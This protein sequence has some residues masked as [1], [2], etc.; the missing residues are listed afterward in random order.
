MMLEFLAAPNQ[1][2]NNHEGYKE[3]HSPNDELV[4]LDDN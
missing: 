3:I 2:G 4:Q 1:G